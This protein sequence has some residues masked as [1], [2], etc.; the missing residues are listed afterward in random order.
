[1]REIKFRAYDTY[2]ERMIYDPYYFRINSNSENEDKKFNAPME[3]AET[4][5]DIDDGIWRPCH[6]MQFT[7]L[8]DKN[9]KEIYEGDI[10]RHDTYGNK[11]SHKIM[12][13]ISTFRLL[14]LLRNEDR[15]MLES[16]YRFIEVIGNVYENS[17]LLK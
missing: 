11:P 14:S 10:I 17:E 1:M 5:Q 6:I 12:Y 8:K 7:G 4:W 3:Y 16:Q 13:F 15:L 9:G 2:N